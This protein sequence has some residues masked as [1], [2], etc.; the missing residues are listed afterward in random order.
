MTDMSNRKPKKTAIE[1]IE[2]LKNKGVRFS[3]IGEAVAEDYLRNHNYYFK[4]ASYRKNYPKHA[5]GNNKDKYIDLE[6]AYLVDLAK[7]DMRFRYRIIQ[8]SL[9][10]EHHTKLQLLRFIEDNQT[11]DGY[12]I[13]E[14]YRNSLSQDQIAI[15]D[16]ELS[17]NANNIYCGAIYSKY[18]GDFPVW[19][20]IEIIPFGRLVDFYKFCANRFNDSLMIDNYYRLLTVKSI[21]NAAAHSNCIFNDLSTGSTVHRTNSRVTH[22]LS[23]I[24]GLSPGFRTLKMSNSRIQEVVT[25]LYTH[26]TLVKSQSVH[27]HESKELH[28]VI[29]RM[30][31]NIHYYDNNELIK[32][33]FEFLRI[34]VDNWY[35]EK[36]NNPT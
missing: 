6:F 16:S 14:D 7:I 28:L 31:K 1:L 33:S 35:K 36:Y 32:S 23:M 18:N 21:R 19:A 12:Q 29:N 13:V 27:D 26:K 9:D 8:I 3:I 20:F 2:H 25:L 5:F 4:L 15:L 17:R 30:Y 22:E 10:I 24:P 11:E 34:V